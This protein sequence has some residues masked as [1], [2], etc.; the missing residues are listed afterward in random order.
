MLL[1]FVLGLERP[2]LRGVV[3]VGLASMSVSAIVYGWLGVSGTSLPGN[4][5]VLVAAACWG[6]YT[7]LSLP[8]LR[9]YLPLSVAAYPRHFG[10]W[11]S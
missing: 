7:T 11:P 1:G 5:L 4:I 8:L 2:N 3:G 9:R 10:G 6:F